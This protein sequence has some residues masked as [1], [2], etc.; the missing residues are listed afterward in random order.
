MRFYRLGLFVALS[1]AVILGGAPLCMAGEDIPMIDVQTLAQSMQGAKKPVLLDVREPQEVAQGKIEG[2]IAIPLGELPARV[3]ELPKNKDIVVY[4][5]SGRR[6]AKAV[7]FLLENGFKHVKNLEGGMIGW[8]SHRPCD[9]KA[10][11]C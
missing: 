3:A 6:S 1:L 8:A 10:S 2:A 4:C 5:R 11:T 9:P 7:S